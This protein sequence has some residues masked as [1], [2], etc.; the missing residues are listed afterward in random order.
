MHSNGGDVKTKQNKRIWNILRLSLCRTPREVLNMKL[1][2][3]LRSRWHN[4]LEKKY[5]TEGRMKVGDS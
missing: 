4:R 1:K 5:N 3:R 2:E